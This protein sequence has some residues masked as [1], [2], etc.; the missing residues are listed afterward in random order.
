[1]KLF[2]K[3]NY[4]YNKHVWSVTNCYNTPNVTYNLKV[5]YNFYTLIP[6]G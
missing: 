6:S 1:M 5:T 4:L 3:H 2:F